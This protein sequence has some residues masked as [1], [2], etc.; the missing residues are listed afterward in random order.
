MATI[1]DLGARRILAKVVDDVAATD[2]D[3]KFAIVPKGPELS[4]GLQTITMKQVSN[5]TN[6]CCNW[7][8]KTIGLPTQSR[9]T[10]AYMA[11]ND[12]R[13]CFF[14]LACQ[15]LGYQVRR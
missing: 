12:V 4:D 13:Y 9:E 7:I 2:P 5:A 6:F 15:K 1:M 3:R 8:E 14:L 10:L 11:A